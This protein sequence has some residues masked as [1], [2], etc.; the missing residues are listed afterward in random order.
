MYYE[1]AQAVYGNLPLG[2]QLV[3]IAGARYLL[4]LTQRGGFDDY[5]YEAQLVLVICHILTRAQPVTR[6]SW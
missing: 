3:S 1:S 5:T 2:E 6:S 4:Y